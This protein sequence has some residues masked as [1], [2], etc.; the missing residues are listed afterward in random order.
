[1]ASPLR[2]EDAL[3]ALI[4]IYIIIYHVWIQVV[5]NSLKCMVLSKDDTDGQL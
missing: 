3:T 4:Y 5:I 2:L 1:M